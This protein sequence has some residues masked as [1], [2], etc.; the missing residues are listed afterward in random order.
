MGLSW[1]SKAEILTP[2][3]DSLLQVIDWLELYS[4]NENQLHSIDQGDCSILFSSRGYGSF[5]SSGN[6][7]P[8]T[9][10]LFQQ[11]C[12]EFDFPI[13]CHERVL[14]C[15]SQGYGFLSVFGKWNDGIVRSYNEISFEDI[16]SNFDPE[17]TWADSAQVICFPTEQI[18][19]KLENIITNASQKGILIQE[20][21]SWW[22]DSY[23]VYYQSSFYELEDEIELIEEIFFKR[24]VLYCTWEPGLINCFTDEYGDNEIEELPLEIDLKKIRLN[25]SCLNDFYY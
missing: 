12:E 8:H 14:P 24:F 7:D 20:S 22:D 16:F 15:Q 17:G 4:E 25:Q 13:I 6:E 2:N 18:P 5:G 23:K 19:S 10:N 1:N 11:I 3:N 21:G 9:G